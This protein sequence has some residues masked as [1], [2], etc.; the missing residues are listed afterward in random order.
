MCWYDVLLK[1]PFGSS[2][3]KCIRRSKKRSL[4]PTFEYL[5]TDRRKIKIEE[6]TKEHHLWL[7]CY[8]E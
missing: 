3:F 2:R 5:D 1:V 8:Y 7:K 4:Q 6:S